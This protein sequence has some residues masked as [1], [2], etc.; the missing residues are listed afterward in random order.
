MIKRVMRHAI[1]RGHLTDGWN[2]HST[3]EALNERLRQLPDAP[4]ARRL[5]QR[6][7]YKRLV[8]LPATEVPAE[9][10]EW[11]ATDPQLVARVE[12]RLAAEL[13]LEP[14]ELLIDFPA[15][16]EMVAV[17]LPVKTRAGA[18]EPAQLALEP[19]TD[20]LHRNARRLRIFCAERR[21]LDAKTV[22]QLAEHTAAEVRDELASGV[23]L[24]R[25]GEVPGS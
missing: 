13:D 19:V 23:A 4:L 8:D 3:D 9:G 14:G 20:A 18:T 6:Q 10:G 2:A 25:G 1:A 22:L 16:P 12:D 5:R 24:L 17:D 21:A 15:K 11:I 7:L